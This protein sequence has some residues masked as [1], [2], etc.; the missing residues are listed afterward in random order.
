VKFVVEHTFAAEIAAYETLFFDEPFCVALGEALGLGRELLRLERTEST[1]VRHVRCEP[2]RDP[3]SA[4]GKAFG[5]SRAS[6]VE[7]LAYDRA[8]HVATWRTIPNVF[9]DR[10]KTSGTIEL[11]AA[12]DGT[13][14]VVR[15]EVVARLFGFGGLVERAVVQ[16]IEKSYEATA[17][18]TER[19]LRG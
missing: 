14:R 1:I 9:P 10:V 15:G 3:E 7:E 12:G 19:W 6:Y 2:R 8:T 18:F 13:R 16:E 5:S 17:R 11:V 4:A